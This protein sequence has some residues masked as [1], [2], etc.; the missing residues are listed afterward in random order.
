MDT[1]LFDQLRQLRLPSDGYAIFG[2]GPLA[3]RNIIPTCN[4]LDILCKQNVWDI[5]SRD[6]VTEL[7]PEYDVTVTSFFDGNITFGTKWGIG[8]FDVIEL[9]ETAEIIDSLP[10]VR[11]EH[12]VRYKTIRS[13][14][15]DLQHLNSLQESSHSL[16]NV[17]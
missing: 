3:I 13:S 7:L 15:K 11:L 2:S 6:G 5:V 10:F 9:I 1:T 12:V 16:G 4:D 17:K 8:D 14:A